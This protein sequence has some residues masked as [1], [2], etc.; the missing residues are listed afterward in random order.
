MDI[1]Q[2]SFINLQRVNKNYLVW[3]K[4]IVPKLPNYDY[5]GFHC[6]DKSKSGRGMK[7]YIRKNKDH[8]VF[9]IGTEHHPFILNFRYFGALNSLQIHRFMLPE[10]N[11]KFGELLKHKN[12]KINK[13]FKF[14]TTTIDANNIT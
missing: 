4:L 2:G 9:Y 13:R 8:D 5:W 10:L 1:L 6:L 12:I 3:I 11:F 7:V 14:T